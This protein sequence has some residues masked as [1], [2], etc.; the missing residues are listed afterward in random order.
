MRAIFTLIVAVLLCGNLAKAQ[1]TLYIY[2]SGAVVDKRAVAEIDSITFYKKVVPP[3]ETVN[4]IEGNVYTVLTI[5]TQKWFK[6]NL[7]TTKFNDGVAIPNVTDNAEWAAQ[8]SPAYSWYNNDANLAG[9]SHGIMYNWYAVETFKVC[10][11]GWHCA[12]FDEWETLNNFLGGS[13]VSGGAMKTVSGGTLWY[14]NWDGANLGA[15]NSSGFTGVPTGVRTIDGTFGDMGWATRW[16]T[17]TED[18]A[19][20]T[21]GKFKMLH[22]TTANLWQGTE[23]KTAGYFVRCIKDK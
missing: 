4:D 2:K 18:E 23:L 10:P 22:S 11:T 7:K 9:T 21:K 6:E 5:G 1:D 14:E 16:W 20:A 19:D 15:T 13:E 8:D 12:T 17:E 3:A